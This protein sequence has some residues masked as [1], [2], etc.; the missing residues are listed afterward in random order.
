MYRRG[1]TNMTYAYGT[2]Q[3]HWGVSPKGHWVLYDVKK[4]PGCK[5]DL[6]AKKPVMISKLS[7]SYDKWWD[8]IFPRNDGQGR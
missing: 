4:D 3:Y 7:V 6:S 8:N 2:A 1:S 5:N